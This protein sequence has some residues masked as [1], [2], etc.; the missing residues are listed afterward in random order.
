MVKVS[1]IDKD[2]ISARLGM[3]VTVEGCASHQQ[4]I[5]HLAS[6][7]QC[8]ADLPGFQEGP[9]LS[10]AGQMMPQRF[11]PPTVMSGKQNN[12]SGQTGPI[13][14]DILERLARVRQSDNY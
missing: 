14:L 8:W 3:R 13:W 4:T 5:P 9:L 2:T 7:G 12:H 11:Q 6:A 1:D 10:K